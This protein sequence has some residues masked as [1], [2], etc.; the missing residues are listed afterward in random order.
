[1]H[2]ARHAA[3]TLLVQQGVPA[4]VA[5]EILGYC[6]IR[7]TLGTY[8]HVVPELAHEAADRIGDALWGRVAH[9]LAHKPGRPWLTGHDVRWSGGSRL[10]ESNRRPSHY[11]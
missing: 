4:R 8:T 2:D 1:L 11:E 5:M 3:A 10:S 7:L 9:D 6:Q